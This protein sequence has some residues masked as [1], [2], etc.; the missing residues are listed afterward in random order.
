M[1]QHWYAIQSKPRRETLAEENLARQG[2]T[3]YLPFIQQ[4]KRRRDK[5]VQVTEPL[6]PRYL[7]IQ[8]DPMQQSLA[9][10]RA[11]LGVAGLVRFGQLLRPV[12]GSV[13][14]YLQAAE[15]R[16]SKQRENNSWPHQPGDKVEVL[17]GP[18]VGLTGIYQMPLAEQRALLL[19]EMLGRSNE[20]AIDIHALGASL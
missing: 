12:P 19:V 14:C 1:P 16:Q 13:I 5:W 9:P 10:V 17:A 11:T 18:L 4:R 3:T 15:N 8:A 2:Y 20:V 6:F 7:F